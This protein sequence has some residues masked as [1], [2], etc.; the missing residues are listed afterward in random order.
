MANVSVSI[1]D[2][3]KKKMARF[4]SVNWS[5]VGSEAFMQKIKDMEFLLEFKSN[6]KLTEEDAL[7]LGAEVN[8]SLARRLE[9]HLSKQASIAKM[10]GKK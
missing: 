5:A 2:E 1:P 3:L 10:G 4:P 7:R 6:S 9:A 8:T